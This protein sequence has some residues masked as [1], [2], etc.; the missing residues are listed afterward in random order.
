MQTRY[1]EKDGALDE[2]A[3]ILSLAA[4]HLKRSPEWSLPL[5]E[6]VARRL[7]PSVAEVK[8]EWGDLSE[9]INAGSLRAGAAANV[10]QTI[11]SLNAQWGHYLRK[12]RDKY[13][14][15]SDY[16]AALEI[17][18]KVSEHGSLSQDDIVVSAH[19]HA[20][21]GH[22]DNALALIDQL[23]NV[24]DADG[25]VYRFRAS[26]LAR[27]GRYRDA[28]VAAQEA[29]ARLPGEQS[30]AA[31]LERI[32]AKRI[33]Q[34]LALRS[35]WD[36]DALEAAI[37]LT[38]IRGDNASDF[39]ALAHLQALHGSV[40]VAL[41]TVERAIALNQED[42]ESHRLRASLLERMGRFEEALA[43][44][45]KV[46]ELL[47]DLAEGEVDLQRII[48]SR[49]E[50]LTQL[51]DSHFPDAI[52]LEAA[53]ELD[54]IGGAE[55]KDIALLAH[56][57][58]HNGLLEQALAT[59]DR[60]IALNCNDGES[61]RLKASLLERLGMFDAALASI[62]KSIALIPGNKEI[63]VDKKRLRAKAICSRF[64]RI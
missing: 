17:C 53:Y 14:A 43:S 57:Q 45:R 47:P 60:G 12:Q 34:L 23:P 42:G 35:K 56:I 28:L 62:K 3:Q 1:K 24:P 44:A 37:E 49:Y 13:F 52:A 33:D 31:D 32:R 7:F 11:T 39:A 26:I 59:I 30:V 16:G 48:S 15:E 27:L 50:E 19:I 40:E 54:R 20:G 10:E 2:A 25:E 41:T 29:N 64:L 36:L 38:H 51:R 6:I 5:I 55:G 18:T 61:F 21:A 46:I 4:A 9:F 22:L 58:A 63:L 8:S